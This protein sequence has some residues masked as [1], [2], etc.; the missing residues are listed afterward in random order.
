MYKCKCDVLTWIQ[1]VASPERPR[2]RPTDTSSAPSSPAHL[3]SRFLFS[4]SDKEKSPACSSPTKSARKHP[5]LS[6]LSA[7]SHKR[8][9]QVEPL[10]PSINS[11]VSSHSLIGCPCG[12]QGCNNRAHSVSWPEVLKGVPNQ[13][14]DCFVR[15]VFSVSLLCFWYM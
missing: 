1:A 11:M 15:A 2:S 4:S 6:C 12:L 3:L 7:K 8:Q 10:S 5:I 14:V 9:R 13:G